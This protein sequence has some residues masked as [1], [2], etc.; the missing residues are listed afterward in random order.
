MKHVYTIAKMDIVAL[1][2]LPLND[3]V[4]AFD[5]KYKTLVNPSSW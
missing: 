1:L 3:K 4:T 2:D 5:S